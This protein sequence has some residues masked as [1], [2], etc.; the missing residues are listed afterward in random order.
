MLGLFF[1]S[2][3]PAS[4][5]QTSGFSCLIRPA[6]SDWLRFAKTFLKPGDGGARRLELAL[7]CKNAHA[8]RQ[9]TLA[10]FSS[11]ADPT[12]VA[13]QLVQLVSVYGMRGRQLGLSG[14]IW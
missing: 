4:L 3:T 9:R 8:S 11:M 6:G 5:A 2:E 13:M 12:S 10:P 14:W 7:F 1:A